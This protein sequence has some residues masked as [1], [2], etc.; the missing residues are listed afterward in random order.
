VQIKIC[1]YATILRFL[2]LES[3]LSNVDRGELT[4]TTKCQKEYIFY[5]DMKG[6]VINFCCKF[7]L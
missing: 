7:K 5:M 3:R 2:P 6:I 1:I 4:V